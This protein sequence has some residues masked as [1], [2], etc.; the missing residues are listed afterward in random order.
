MPFP[1][2]VAYKPIDKPAIGVNNY[3]GFNPGESEVLPKIWNGYDA[4]PLESDIRIDRDVEVVVRDGCR[5]YVDV[6]RPA[7]AQAKVPAI[8]G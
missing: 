3:Q 6:C 7:D 5:L 8:L 2:Q 4:W 1:V